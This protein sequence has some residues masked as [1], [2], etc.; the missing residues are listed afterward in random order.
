HTTHS[1]TVR[2]QTSGISL[3]VPTLS[4]FTADHKLVGT[5]AAAGPLHGD[6]S[7]R[8]DNVKP[9]ETYYFK[10][11]GA[12]ADVFD[13]GSYRLKIDFGDPASALTINLLDA[14]YIAGAAQGRRPG[15]GQLSRDGHGPGSAEQQA[16]RLRRQREDRQGRRHGLLPSGHAR[17]DGRGA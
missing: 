10:V 11:E 14:A 7:V 15:R 9:G 8:L 2:V 1:M 3:M 6:V 13:V 17:R 4:V 12:T 5:A 16:L